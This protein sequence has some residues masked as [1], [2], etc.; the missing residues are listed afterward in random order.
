MAG[1]ITNRYATDKRTAAAVF[2]WFS[3]EYHTTVIIVGY[4]IFQD[5][6]DTAEKLRQNGKRFFER[7]CQNN[8]Y[9]HIEF[10]RQVP[11]GV[12]TPYRDLQCP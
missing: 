3:L 9:L 12:G 6:R 10:E 7:S 4:H 5:H 8:S 2:R 1:I 11:A